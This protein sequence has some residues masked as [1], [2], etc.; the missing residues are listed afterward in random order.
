MDISKYFKKFNKFGDIITLFILDIFLEYNPQN[1]LFVRTCTTGSWLDKIFIDNDRV[2]RI[3]YYTDKIK[4]PTTS[5]KSTI[6]IN[7][8]NLESK[9]S[10]LNKKYD[11]I[12]I[13]TWHEYN[14]SIRDLNIISQYLNNEG[15]LISHDCCPW[16]KLVANPQ[17]IEGAWCGETYISFVNFAYNNPKLYYAIIN[18]DTGIGIISK[19]KMPFLSNKLNAIKQQNLLYLYKNNANYYDYFMHNLKDIINVISYY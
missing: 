8:N 13:D 7:S 9:L 1:I 14:M 4:Q 12:C 5:H 19:R 16:N 6:I 18:I 15:T 10:S 3:L 17:F 2:D 11:L